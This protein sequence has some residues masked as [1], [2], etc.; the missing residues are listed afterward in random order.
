[1]PLASSA[2]ALRSFDGLR[3]LNVSRSR[4]KPLA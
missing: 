1:M 4:L 2:R 3:P